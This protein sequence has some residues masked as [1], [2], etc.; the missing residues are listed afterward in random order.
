M[1]EPSV[2]ARSI[3]PPPPQTLER[4]IREIAGDLW[5]NAELLMRQELKLGVVEL[6]QRAHAL[7][8]ELKVAAAGAA[9]LYVGILSLVAAAILLL[10]EVVQPWI[11]AL[12]VGGCASALGYAISQREPEAMID[13]VTTPAAMESARDRNPPAQQIK[14]ALK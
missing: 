8:R 11:A 14:E 12:I 10:S 2:P 9:M 1:L 3:T 13:A 6:E 7:K 4:P 5:G